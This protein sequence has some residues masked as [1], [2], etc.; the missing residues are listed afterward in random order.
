M[1]RTLSRLTKLHLGKKQQLPEPKAHLDKPSTL[2]YLDCRK[3]SI[4]EHYTS[5]KKIF[6]TVELIDQVHQWVMLFPI[7][8]GSKPLKILC[9]NMRFWRKQLSHWAWAMHVD[10][11][12][13]LQWHIT[14][15]LNQISIRISQIPMTEYF[16]KWRS[17]QM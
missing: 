14:L 12:K 11:P 8:M 7:T 6:N 4:T 16:S 17:L 13:H 15:Y 10:I 1:K 2:V 3:S 9:K 5:L